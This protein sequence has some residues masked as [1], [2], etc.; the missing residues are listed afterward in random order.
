MKQKINVEKNQNGAQ[1]KLPMS[2]FR[3]LFIFTS[4][5]FFFHL[6]SMGGFEDFSTSPAFLI[7]LLVL[8]SHFMK[9]SILKEHQH[10]G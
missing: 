4:I 7:D 3:L 5:F 2:S 8:L 9:I 6:D 10:V 1:L